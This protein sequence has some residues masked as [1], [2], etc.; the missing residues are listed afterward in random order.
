[1]DKNQKSFRY[2]RILAFSS[3]WMCGSGSGS[4]C[5]PRVSWHL[6]GILGQNCAESDQRPSSVLSYSLERERDQSQR[7]WAMTLEL[8]AGYF[9]IYLSVFCHLLTSPGWILGIN[10]GVEIKSFVCF[11]IFDISTYQVYGSKKSEPSQNMK[12][13]LFCW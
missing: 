4:A 6:I 5:Y 2:C 3:M 11:K 7:T 10:C 1:M 13:L 8:G 9:P 12:V